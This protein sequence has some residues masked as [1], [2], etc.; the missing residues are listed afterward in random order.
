MHN[1]VVVLLPFE[2]FAAM[3]QSSIFEMFEARHC[4]RTT[5]KSDPS[6][7]IFLNGDTVHSVLAMARFSKSPQPCSI[8]YRSLHPA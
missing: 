6:T 1:F 5:E 8:V 2:A 7:R 3:L 4:S